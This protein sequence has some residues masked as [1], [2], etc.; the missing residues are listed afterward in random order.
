MAKP[1][2]M[3]FWKNTGVDLRNR[4]LD[5]GGADAPRGRDNFW[6]CLGHIANDAMQQKGS[7]SMPGKCK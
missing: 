2:D 3:L 4:V 7:F 1:I 5:G 6:G